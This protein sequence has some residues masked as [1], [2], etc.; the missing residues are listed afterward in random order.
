MRVTYYAFHFIPDQA[1]YNG[2]DNASVDLGT[3]MAVNRLK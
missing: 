3:T 2:Y 1:K